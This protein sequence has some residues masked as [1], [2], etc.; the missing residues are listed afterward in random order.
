MM[1]FGP[2]AQ[3]SHSTLGQTPVPPMQGRTPM[4]A[5]TA[6]SAPTPTSPG[7]GVSEPPPPGVVSPAARDHLRRQSLRILANGGSEADVVAFLRLEGHKPP[8]VIVTGGEADRE[9]G[10]LEG[11]SM[12]AVQGL[13]FGFGDEVIGSI[14]GVLSGEGARGGVDAYRDDYR[15]WAE[16]NK[17][18]AVAAELLGALG[19]GGVGLTRAGVTAAAGLSRG[20]RAARA[21][22][23]GAVGGGLEAA[24]RTESAEGASGWE[25]LSDRAK[26]AIFGASAGALFTGG[27]VGAGQVAGAVARPIMRGASSAALPEPLA[28]TLQRKIPGLGT[29]DEHAREILWR[30]LEADGIKTVP[31]LRTKIAELAKTGAPVTL[32][33]IG[34]EA[35]MRLA[36]EASALRSPMQQQLIDALA[37]RQQE[38]GE[39]LMGKA[40]TTVLRGRKLGARNAY[41]AAEKLKERQIAAATP[42]YQEAYQQTLPVSERAKA[43]M[44]HP[45]FKDAWRRGKA[46]ADDEDLAGTGHGLKVPDLNFG[47]AEDALGKIRED[48]LKANPTMNPEFATRIAQERM[49]QMGGAVMEEISELPIRGLDYM[50]RGLDLVI[51][52]G[53]KEGNLDQ[54]GAV[55][56]RKM[57]DDVLEEADAAIPKYG[58][59]RALWRDE[60]TAIRLLDEGREAFSKRHH[61]HFVEKVMRDPKITPSQKD[62]YRVGALQAMADEIYNKTRLVDDPARSVFGGTPSG[63]KSYAADRIRALFPE[64][65]GGARAAQNLI[66]RINVEARLAET[67]RKG[68]GGAKGR[69]ISEFERGAEGNLPQIR[70]SEQLT[71]MGMV[72][73]GLQNVKDRFMRDVSDDISL[74][75]TKGIDDPRE[76]DILAESLFRT[77]Q[78]ATSKGKEGFKVGAAAALGTLP[79]KVLEGN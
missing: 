41:E 7:P 77:H 59:A 1:N 67:A 4:M 47:E 23:A 64:G 25:R 35:T 57:L 27:L 63:R 20:A 62:M 33:D 72:R 69:A 51:A 39:R 9:I 58:A 18:T 13:T 32:A 75:F 56:L 19:T 50:K 17:G 70:M 76:L 14:L 60:E 65:E 21:M 61:P 79:G 15:R 11:L 36:A 71:A 34:G 44:E 24:G 10:T 74:L 30:A 8:E 2:L 53:F 66:D 45:K 16:E 46:L 12:A 78:K 54:R 31:Q 73:D 28:Q 6:P 26:A 37:T 22:G 42:L 5:P 49:Q 52:S 38:A 68:V 40:I 29:S 55:A 48:I 3:A 43:L